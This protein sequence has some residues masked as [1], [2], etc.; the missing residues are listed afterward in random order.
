MDTILTSVEMPS[1]DPGERCAHIGG[2]MACC[3]KLL[4]IVAIV[5]GGGFTLGVRGQFIAVLI[6]GLG[7][8]ITY[9]VYSSNSQLADPIEL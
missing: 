8:A 3:V 2:I 1:E 7:A 6:V 9:L 5:S 4:I